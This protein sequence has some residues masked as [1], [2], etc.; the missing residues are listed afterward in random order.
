MYFYYNK[1]GIIKMISEKKIKS[2]LGFVKINPNADE[3]EKLLRGGYVVSLDKNK[4]KFE[5]HPRARI[6]G[7]EA[8]KKLLKSKVE[9][10]SLTMVDIGNFITKYL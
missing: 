6:R 5:E 4:L 7:I 2:D 3:S 8:E 1:S 9:D 10:G